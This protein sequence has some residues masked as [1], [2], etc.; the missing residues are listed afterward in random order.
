MIQYVALLRGINV[1]GNHLIKMPE[2]R[3]CFETLGFGNVATYI[4]SG[5]VLFEAAEQEPADLTARIEEALAAQFGYAARIVLRSHDQ[6]RAIVA[7][8]PAGFGNQPERYRYDVI[9]LREP[10]T[11]AEAM[12]QLRTR[13]G[14]DQA[15]AGDGVCY[16][17]RLASR[18]A[19]SYL[20]RIV[21][22]PVYQSMTIRNWNTTVKL[23]AL[24]DARAA[25]PRRSPP[26]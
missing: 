5:N 14:V 4:Q 11:V 7:G 21:A 17:A 10:L 24:M 15:C 23:R 26:V 3:L 1:G 6:M 16:F 22:L 8:A 20:S 12:R 19:Q 13:E 2:L 25:E 18:A 9:F